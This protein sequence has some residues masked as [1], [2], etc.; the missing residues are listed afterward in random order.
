MC[1]NLQD[2]KVFLQKKSLAEIMDCMNSNHIPN[3]ARHLT[4]YRSKSSLSGN[5]RI[6]LINNANAIIDKNI[7][8]LDTQADKKFVHPDAFGHDVYWSNKGH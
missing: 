6:Y 5:N 4:D 8:S 2:G 7:K 3:D 1:Y